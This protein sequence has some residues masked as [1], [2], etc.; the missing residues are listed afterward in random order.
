MRKKK[1]IDRY[2]Q[3]QGDI[4]ISGIKELNLEVCLLHGKAIKGIFQGLFVVNE[5]VDLE[6]VVRDLLD[7]EGVEILEPLK[8]M[9]VHVGGREGGGERWCSVC[10]VMVG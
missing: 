1:K 7:E 9:F 8:L 10:L 4:M 5:R 6:M 3:M 2:V